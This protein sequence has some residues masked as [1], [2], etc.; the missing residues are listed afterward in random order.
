MQLRYVHPDGVMKIIKELKNS[1]STGTDN[2]DTKLVAEDILP[3]ITHIINLSIRQQEFQDSSKLAKVILLLKKG[4]PLVPKNYR[5][6]ALLPILNKIL[7][8]AVLLQIVD[9]LDSNHLIHPNHYGCRKG[10][11]TATALIQMYDKWVEDVEEGKLV[12]V[13]CCI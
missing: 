1:K 5:P 4:D 6:V 12:G 8:K 10:H 11:N 2:I 3:A 9:Y 7:D 13:M